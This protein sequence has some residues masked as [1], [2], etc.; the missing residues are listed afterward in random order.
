MTLIKNY[1]MRNLLKYLPV[2]L[3]IE[4]CAGILLMFK[5]PSHGVA[6]LKGIFWVARNIRQIYA[7]RQIVQRFRKINDRDI[8]KQME[9]SLLNKWFLLLFKF[10]H[11]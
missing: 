7:R 10:L 9:K 11:A 6:R 1:Q 4:F 5:E 3:T 8:M 2:V